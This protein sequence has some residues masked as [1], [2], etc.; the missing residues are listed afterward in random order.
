MMIG[1][2][3]H[4]YGTPTI[5]V[6]FGVFILLLG[7]MVASLNYMN[8]NTIRIVLYLIVSLGLSAITTIH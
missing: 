3:I 5:Y 7:I 1:H 8:N 6:M 4:M 2:F